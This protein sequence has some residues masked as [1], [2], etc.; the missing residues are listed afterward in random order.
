[1]PNLLA[2]CCPDLPDID[3]SGAS[4]GDCVVVA[5]DGVSLITTPCAATSGCGCALTVADLLTLGGTGDVGDP[6]VVGETPGTAPNDFKYWN[7]S[8]WVVGQAC[9]S[10]TAGDGPASVSSSETLCIGETLHA[11]SA[12]SVTIDLPGGDQ[13]HLEVEPSTDGGNALTVGTDGKLYVATGGGGGGGVVVKEAGVPVATRAG[14][15]L[16]AGTGIS[17]GIVDD[18]GSDDVNITITNTAP[19]GG[20]GGG[21]EVK[22]AGT[23]IGTR[24]GIDLYAGSG[25]SLSVVDDPGS[26]DV[27]VTISNVGAGSLTLAQHEVPIGGTAG[28]YKMTHRPVT[29][30]SYVDPSNHANFAAGLFDARPGLQAALDEGEGVPVELPTDAIMRIT[31]NF[32]SYSVGHPILGPLVAAGF[33]VGLVDRYPFRRV[34]S[35]GF[36]GSGATGGINEPLNNRHG[37]SQIVSSLNLAAFVYVDDENAGSTSPGADQRGGGWSYT[38]FKDISGNQDQALFGFLVGRRWHY[39]IDHNSFVRIRHDGDVVPIGSG[40][41][42][43]DLEDM[44]GTGIVS[45]T[46]IPGQESV[47]YLKVS[48]NI[49]E[50]C[51][52]GYFMYHDA[53]DTHI[54]DNMFYGVQKETVANGSDSPI[55]LAH[56][57]TAIFINGLDIWVGRNRNQHTGR[58]IHVWGRGGKSRAVIIDAESFENPVVHNWSASERNQTAGLIIDGSNI[59]GVTV[60]DPV[61]ANGGSYG[62]PILVDPSVPNGGWSLNNPHFGGTAPTGSLAINPSNLWI[63]DPSRR[64]VGNFRETISGILREYAR[65]EAGTVLRREITGVVPAWT[66]SWTQGT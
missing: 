19:G 16:Y 25:I 28:L 57:G 26:D 29:P 38:T 4:P 61:V 3:M 36:A 30:F 41:T 48:H 42:L 39:Q 35:K 24:A 5:P 59:G 45:I 6:W 21:V 15:D 22:D 34:F 11:W 58:G 9:I 10:L 65:N 46:D 47:Q 23:T 53:P 54:W 27:N 13:L 37:S 52:N 60:N 18:P 50:R 49:Y 44:P 33:Q 14:I 51:I 66:S 55:P 32:N 12:G 64:T 43:P 31:S 7:G 1:M 17:I 63:V 62:A 20:G 56:L 40:S 8:S 2:P